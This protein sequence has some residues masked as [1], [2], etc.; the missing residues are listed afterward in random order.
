MDLY[1][2]RY[3]CKKFN[4]VFKSVLVNVKIQ[5]KKFVSDRSILYIYILFFI[6]RQLYVSL[7]HKAFYSSSFQSLIHLQVYMYVYIQYIHAH[8][9]SLSLA[10]YLLSFSHQQ[11]ASIFL[12]MYPKLLIFLQ[13]FFR[14]NI[15]D[16][17][18]DR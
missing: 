7:C 11:F 8:K 4:N 12:F 6:Y 18:R 3:N 15:F 10:C 14:S 5:L 13:L 16:L 17:Y 1:I 2:N 9:L